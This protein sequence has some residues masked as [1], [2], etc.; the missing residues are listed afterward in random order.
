M[1]VTYAFTA[2]REAQVV[3][4]DFDT[5]GNRRQDRLIEN[6]GRPCGPREL[7]GCSGRDVMRSCLFREYP[8]N[9]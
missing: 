8:Q 6:V 2:A 1:A 4:E 9:R 7:V 3:S 5:T